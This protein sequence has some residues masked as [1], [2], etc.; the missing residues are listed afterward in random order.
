MACS[1]ISCNCVST[2][3]ELFIQWSCSRKTEALKI[4][5]K[6]VTG[7]KNYRISS[8]VANPIAS[9]RLDYPPSRWPEIC[10]LW[11][12]LFSQSKEKDGQKNQKD[13]HSIR[14]W[15][16]MVR[17]GSKKEKKHSWF[18]WSHILGGS[19]LP[20]CQVLF[21]LVEL[22]LRSPAIPQDQMSGGAFFSCEYAQGLRPCNLAAVSV[23]KST[24]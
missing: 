8:I 21:F 10:E 17:E 20:R 12:Y 18:S 2:S 24:W 9:C 4:R 11:H 14:I 3:P 1:C 13:L 5:E 19:S 6:F 7:R 16:R 22:I 23:V 15:K